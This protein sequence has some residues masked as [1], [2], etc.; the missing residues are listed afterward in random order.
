[1]TTLAVV[2]A[3]PARPAEAASEQFLPA[4]MVRQFVA[5]CT[6]PDRVGGYTR[7]DGLS[8]W[9]IGED[10]L[11]HIELSYVDSATN[12]T[13]V[14]EVA[15]AVATVCLQ[16][17]HVQLD[18]ADR[19]PTPAQMLVIREWFWRWEAPCLSAHGISLGDVSDDDDEVLSPA[20]TWYLRTRPLADN[21]ERELAA[22]L[23]C[24]P[25]P[26]YLQ[27]AGVGF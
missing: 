14:D 12:A 4:D 13:T 5:Y 15:T 21:F 16:K 19:F 22:R 23:A 24:E 26:P 11:V 10:A 9:W 20:V 7:E 8:S 2:T 1:M 6:P 18:R 25:M 17:R 3:R 27:N